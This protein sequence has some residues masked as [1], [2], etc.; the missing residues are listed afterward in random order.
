MSELTTT[1]FNRILHYRSDVYD[2]EIIK[3]VIDSDSYHVNTC[4]LNAGIIIDI[5]AHIGSFS[6]MA[7]CLWPDRTVKAFEMSPDNYSMLC[8]NVSGFPGVQPSNVAVIG[9]RIPEGFA[10]HPKN[11][12]GCRVLWSAGGSALPNTIRASDL[13]NQSVA[14]LKMDCEGMEH[15]ILDDLLSSNHLSFVDKIGMEYH[16]F[17][18]LDGEHNL[19]SL[20]KSAGFNVQVQR[21]NDLCGIFWASRG[22]W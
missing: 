7:A 5:G 2:Y 15:Y 14:F 18:D 6:F 4:N 13:F 3:E 12:G 10:T 20:L 9:K 17:W 22:A 16:N 11:S 1:R 8:K 19:Q 21:I